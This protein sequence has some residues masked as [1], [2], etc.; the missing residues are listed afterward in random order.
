[1]CVALALDQGVLVE[2]ALAFTMSILLQ[3]CNLMHAVT[4]AE[5]GI[6]TTSLDSTSMAAYIR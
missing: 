2:P 6:P 3:V 4:S 1:M 5:S